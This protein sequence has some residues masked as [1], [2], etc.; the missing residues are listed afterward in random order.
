LPYSLSSSS[1]L[2]ISSFHLVYLAKEEEEEE[3]DRISRKKIKQQ[4]K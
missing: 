1:F 2:R 3:E 4:L